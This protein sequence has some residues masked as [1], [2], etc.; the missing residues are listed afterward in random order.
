MRFRIAFNSES[1]IQ[2]ARV[3]VCVCVCV[4]SILVP[5]LMPPAEVL[6]ETLTE[7]GSLESSAG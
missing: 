2:E 3:C 5:N 6:S 1:V 7:P 4:S